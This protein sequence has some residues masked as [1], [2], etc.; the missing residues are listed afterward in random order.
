MSSADWS[1]FPRLPV[2]LHRLMGGSHAAVPV[3]SVRQWTP[4]PASSVLSQH[5]FKHA[6]ESCR[7]SR[8]GG[9]AEPLFTLGACSEGLG[10]LRLQVALMSRGL[11]AV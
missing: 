7:T 4:S 3:A 5:Y 1:G 8:E 11:N 6:N 2:P 10:P 9:T